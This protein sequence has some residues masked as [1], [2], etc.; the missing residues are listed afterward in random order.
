MLTIGASSC[1]TVVMNSADDRVQTMIATL[2]RNGKL[3]V[4]DGESTFFVLCKAWR[5]GP[6]YGYAPSLD[7]KKPVGKFGMLSVDMLWNWMAQLQA[8]AK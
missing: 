8:V 7:G 4:S 5:G 3:K 6:P 1:R 2:K